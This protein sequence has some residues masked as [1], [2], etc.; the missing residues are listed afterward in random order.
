M[1]GTNDNSGL[2]PQGDLDA[3]TDPGP[4]VYEEGAA[5]EMD[6]APAAPARG[7]HGE[8]A[9]QGP[10]PQEELTSL[11]APTEQ[12]TNGGPDAE[13][14]SQD[15]FSTYAQFKRSQRAALGLPAEEAQGSDSTTDRI[16][17]GLNWRRLPPAVQTANSDGAE[18]ASHHGVYSPYRPEPTPDPQPSIVLSASVDEPSPALTSPDPR[19]SASTVQLA[20]EETSALVRPPENRQLVMVVAAVL[21]V[22]VLILAAAATLGP[23]D[24][25]ARSTVA[26]TPSSLAPVMPTPSALPTAPAVPPPLS[27]PPL[28]PSTPLPES[29]APAVISA[30]T[31]R[32]DG[33]R[34]PPPPARP[35]PA[36]TNPTPPSRNNQDPL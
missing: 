34:Q 13:P 21:A 20:R 32:G 36:P 23:S 33:R 8:S 28:A 2:P 31:P 27:A 4:P 11:D 14:A 24:G 10:A 15:G 5:T 7:R 9:A 25:P 17:D 19:R 12:A 18:V 1:G 6:R 22:A 3:T 29:A 35:R 16:V 26:P 30:P